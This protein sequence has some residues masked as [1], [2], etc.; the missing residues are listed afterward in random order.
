MLESVPTGV[1]ITSGVVGTLIS[2]AWLARGALRRYSRDVAETTKDR[3]E[4][5]LYSQLSEQVTS[6]RQQADEAVKERNELVA[7]VARLETKLE[8]YENLTEVVNR[9]KEKLDAKDKELLDK[10]TE[11]KNFVESSRL[12]REKFLEI[13]QKKE[14]VINLRDTHLDEMTRKLH[15]MEL[16][17]SRDER[18]MGIH[19]CPYQSAREEFESLAGGKNET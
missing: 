1:S 17:L 12:E 14:E 16:R 13:L 11:F 7:R 8:E 3:A 4:S 6:Y 5:N 10:E 19:G 15:Q 9:L 2:A 18:T